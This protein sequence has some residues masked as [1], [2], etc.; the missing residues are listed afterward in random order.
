MALEFL[1]SDHGKR[2]KYQFEKFEKVRFFG[3]LAFNF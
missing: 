1:R 2:I 3:F